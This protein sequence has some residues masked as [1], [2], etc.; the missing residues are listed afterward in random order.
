MIEYTPSPLEATPLVVPFTVMFTLGM[1]WPVPWSVTLPL[2]EDCANAIEQLIIVRAKANAGFR[3]CSM[4]IFWYLSVNLVKYIK[5][6]YIF[7]VLLI[8]E[9]LQAHIQQE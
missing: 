5:W 9:R 6:Q 1:G 4:I 2:T 3:I 7:I 8:M